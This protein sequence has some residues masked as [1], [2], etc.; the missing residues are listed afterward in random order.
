[1]DYDKGEYLSS[2]NPYVKTTPRRWT[3]SEIEYMLQLKKDGKSVRS[4]YAMAV[5]VEK[6]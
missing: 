3:D 6:Q 2:N 5:G 1:M 4:K